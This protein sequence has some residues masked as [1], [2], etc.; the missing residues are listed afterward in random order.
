M[1]ATLTFSG[2]IFTPVRKENRHGKGNRHRPW[3]NEFLCCRDGRKQSKGYRELGRWTYHSLDGG[4][5]RKR[6]GLGRTAGKAP[7]HHQRGKHYLRNKAPDWP[8]LR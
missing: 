6:R 3:N 7:E 4:I 1:A 5:R 8:A 2:V